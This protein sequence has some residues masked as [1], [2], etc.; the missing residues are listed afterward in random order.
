[1]IVVKYPKIKSSGGYA[2]LGFFGA[3]RGESVPRERVRSL[4]LPP[5]PAG[6]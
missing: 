1:M 4:S 3:Y 2:A 5:V 6:E